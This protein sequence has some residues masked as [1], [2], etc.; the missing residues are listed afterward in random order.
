[1]LSFIKESDEREVMKM[2]NST[3]VLILMIRIASTLLI[4]SIKN[5]RP[6]QPKIRAIIF[7]L[8]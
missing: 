4:V 6:V 2:D 5:N 8:I 1:M 3:L 7:L